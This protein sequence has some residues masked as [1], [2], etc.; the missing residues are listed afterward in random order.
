MAKRSG[1]RDRPEVQAA[2]RQAF[3]AVEAAPTPAVLTEHL[4]RLTAPKPGR[5]ERS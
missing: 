5:G 4:D 3:K 2:L 1:P